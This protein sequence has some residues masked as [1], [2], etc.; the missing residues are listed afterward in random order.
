MKPTNQP[1]ASPQK[2]RRPAPK[3]P[4]PP[5]Q[6]GT[7]NWVLMGVGLL[8]II[9]G[10]ITLARGSITLAPILLVLGYCVLIPVSLLVSNR[11]RS[12]PD[13]ANETTPAEQPKVGSSGN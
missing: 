13:A 2:G 5:I 8:V 7:V 1:A 11:P 6:L 10:F 4:R 12:R 3:K 9:T